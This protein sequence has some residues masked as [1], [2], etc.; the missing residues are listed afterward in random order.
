MTHN[1]AV[2]TMTRDLL[3]LVTEAHGKELEEV[4]KFMEDE[5]VREAIRVYGID[6]VNEVRHPE[7]DSS[8]R[9]ASDMAVKLLSRGDVTG[10]V[11]RWHGLKLGLYGNPSCFLICENGVASACC[12]R[13]CGSWGLRAGTMRLTVRILK[14]VPKEVR[15][16]EAA[17]AAC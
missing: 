1:E 4:R 16:A 17:L 7:R 10:E 6:A 15:T 3:P 8:A 13:V 14:K 2:E 5:G 11:Y 12:A 9:T